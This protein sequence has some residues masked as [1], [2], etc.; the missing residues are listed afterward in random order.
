MCQRHLALQFLKHKIQAIIR[1]RLRK[2][3]GNHENV[4]HGIECYITVL[5]T[6]DHE[7]IV[8]LLTI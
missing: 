3:N 8:G 1:N 5:Q 2:L 6:N 7:G 4:S